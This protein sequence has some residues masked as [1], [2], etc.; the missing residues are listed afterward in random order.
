[1]A[2]KVQLTAVLWQE[3]DSWVSLNPETGVAS[4]GDSLE[5]AL[6][7]LQEALELYFEETHAEVIPHPTVTVGHVEVK[8]S[9]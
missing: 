4:C 2:E 8:L 5:E 6:T 7:M 3:E 1:M 9:A